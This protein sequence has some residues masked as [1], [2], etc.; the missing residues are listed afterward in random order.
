MLLVAFLVAAPAFVLGS[1]PNVYT[2][3]G[4]QARRSSACR[5][6]SVST[7]GPSGFPPVVV[8]ALEARLSA[9]V[10]GWRWLQG[11]F[12]LARAACSNLA[13]CTLQGMPNSDDNV[14]SVPVPALRSHPLDKF[15]GLDRPPAHVGKLGGHCMHSC[16]PSANPF[17]PPLEL[18]STYVLTLAAR[19]EAD[20]A[21]CNSCT[22][23][24]ATCCNGCDLP[25]CDGRVALCSGAAGLSL[26][27]VY[28]ALKVMERSQQRCGPSS[29]I[30]N[31]T[32]KADPQ[33]ST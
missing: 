21:W 20:V 14:H 22:S 18:E 32:P 11:T 33:P 7:L 23:L 30:P 17:W 9:Q 13:H 26:E 29:T 3:G 1:M 6:N 12:G 19:A 15:I 8:P 24:S 25:R 28:Q 5:A 31:V 10:S 27:C 4:I 16:E 2:I